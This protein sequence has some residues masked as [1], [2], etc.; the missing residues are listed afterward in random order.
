MWLLQMHAEVADE[1]AT[2]RNRV[3]ALDARDT[4]R[5][6]IEDLYAK[7]VASGILD[8]E[9]EEEEKGVGNGRESNDAETGAE[10]DSDA[11]MASDPVSEIEE[12]DEAGGE[13][14]IGSAPLNHVSVE[15]SAE[16]PAA[17]NEEA[18]E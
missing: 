6:Q 12:P 14:G 13:V 18:P 11:D 1:N 8:P 15:V 4:S 9:E 16:T 2:L 7:L 17:G 5:T 3:A 10:E